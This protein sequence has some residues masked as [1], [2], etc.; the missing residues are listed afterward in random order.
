MKVETYTLA[1]AENYIGGPLEPWAW[2]LCYDP[3]DGQPHISPTWDTGRHYLGDGCECA[4]EM[5][6]NGVM[7]HNAFDG[8]GRYELGLARVH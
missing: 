6:A 2:A 7:V 3:R 4:P 8:R 5:D 1:S